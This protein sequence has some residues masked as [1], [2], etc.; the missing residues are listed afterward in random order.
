M[1]VYL[2]ETKENKEPDFN[3]MAETVEAVESKPKEML[4]E[5]A[6]WFTVNYQYAS[7]ILMDVFKKNRDYTMKAKRQFGELILKTFC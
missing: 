5:G 7:Q 1:K 4:V 6:E 2:G 3:S